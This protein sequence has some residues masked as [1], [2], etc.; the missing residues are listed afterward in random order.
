MS[1][2]SSR[3]MAFGSSIPAT[4]QLRNSVIPIFRSVMSSHKVCWTRMG[5]MLQ[6]L[7]QSESGLVCVL[8]FGGYMYTIAQYVHVLYMCTL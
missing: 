1:F 7:V 2:N 5:S 3:R 6:S 4:L 8:N